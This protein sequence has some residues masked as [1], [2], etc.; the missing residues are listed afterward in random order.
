MPD[1][2][3]LSRPYIIQGGKVVFVSEL[4]GDIRATGD[5]TVA[6]LDTQPINL[7]YL[8]VKSATQVH[9]LLDEL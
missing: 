1:E 3:S 9:R 2:A 7:D 5:V 8:A 4:K 6:F